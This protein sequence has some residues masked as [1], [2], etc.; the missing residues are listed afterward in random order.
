MTRVS[1]SLLLPAV[2]G[3]LLAASAMATVAMPLCYV[4]TTAQC[5]SVIPYGPNYTRTCGTYGN[6]PD[7]PIDNPTIPWVR[8]QS[9]GKSTFVVL[10]PGEEC[11]WTKYGCIGLFGNSCGPL[12]GA[13]SATCH[14]RR[15]AG[16]ACP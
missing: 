6:C 5:C 11:T 9:P 13:G 1:M 4:D 12:G 2:P 15:A 16:S 8:S 3:V 7:I 10:S 14:G